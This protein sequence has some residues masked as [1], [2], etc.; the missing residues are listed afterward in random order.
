MTQ[1]SGAQLLI[2]FLEGRGVTTIAGIPGGAALPIYDALHGSSIT[3]IL[4]RHEQGAGFIAQ[5]MAR[6]TGVPAVTLATSGPGATN[7]VTAVADAYADSIPLLAITGQVPQHLIGTDAFQE[8]DACHLFEK[9]TRKS[10]FARSAEE[11]YEI[12]PKAWLLMTQGRPGPV[13]VDIP[14]DVQLQKVEFR[15]FRFIAPSAHTADAAAIELAARMIGASERPVFYIG[16]GIIASGAAE[17]VTTLARDQGIPVVSS[18]MGLGAFPAKDELFLGMLGMHAAPY[19]NYIM[20]E[21]DLLIAVGVRFDD[22]ATGKLEKFCPGARVIHIDIDARELGKLRQPQLAIEADARVALKGLALA[23]PAPRVRSAWLQRIA[24]LRAAHPHEE[25]ADDNAAIAF[26]QLLDRSRSLDDFI[27]TD[28]GQH[29]MWAAQYLQFDRPRRWLT[30][31]GLGTMGFGLPAAIGASLATGQRSICISGDGSVMMNLQEL[32]TLAE[33]AL[34][35]KIIILDNGHLGLVRQQQTLFF[36]KR[37]SASAFLQPTGFT[38]IAAAFGLP[39]MTVDATDSA[40]LQA[41]LAMP[42]PG[43]AHVPIRAADKVLPMVAPGAGNLEM[44]LRD[45][46]RQR[47]AETN[48]VAGAKPLDGAALVSTVRP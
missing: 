26:M 18:V 2:R 11:L 27:T 30:S 32:Q 9:I 14:K 36:D 45:P 31:G 46:E 44:I 37:L 29:Q 1:I 21:A 25:T 35:V 20:H 23:L 5:G 28:V 24:E 12:L 7:L 8:V 48:R 3:H 40:G 16:G 34:P 19:T 47:T 39:A 33:L 38:A 17:V 43:V 4:A 15:P 42:G 22:R 10:F 13:H 6:A 41:F